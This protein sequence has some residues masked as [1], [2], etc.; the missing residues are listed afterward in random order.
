MKIWFTISA[1]LV[2]ALTQHSNSQINY[3]RVSGFDH[4]SVL[5]FSPDGKLLISGANSKIGIWI[6]STGKLSQTFSIGNA[7]DI[8]DIVF[9]A[10]DTLAISN[11]SDDI[12]IY[13]I[14]NNMVTSKFKGHTGKV[15]YI[16]INDDANRLF[17]SSM[18]HTTI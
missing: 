13:D 4:G 8:N 17:S 7:K 6:P 5:K 9:L 12:L 2:T 3:T 1:M 11:N 15:T 14:K 10:E 16:E 18:D